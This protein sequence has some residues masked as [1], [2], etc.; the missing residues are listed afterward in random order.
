MNAMLYPF[1]MEHI[2]LLRG[3]VLSVY[4]EI[5]PI[6]L[7]GFQYEGRD[8]GDLDKGNKLNIEVTTNF[9]SKLDVISDIIVTKID[10]YILNNLK[11]AIDLG[12]NIV[13]LQDFSE[14]EEYLKEL[15]RKGGVIFSNI[16]NK[17]IF[18]ISNKNIDLALFDVPIVFVCGMSKNTQKFDVFLDLYKNFTKKGYKISGVAARGE[19]AILPVHNIPQFLIEK[20]YEYDKILYFNNY[21]KWLELTEHPDIIFIE[22]PGGIIPYDI[23]HNNQYGV[24]AYIMSQAISSVD[25]A[26]FSMAYNIYDENF[27]KFMSLYAKYRYGFSINMF[28][29]SNCFHDLEVDGN[30]DVILMDKEKLVSKIKE[31]TSLHKDVKMYNVFYNPEVVVEDI[32][33]ELG[34]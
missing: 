19:V 28:H 23:K 18:K 14:Y 34:E 22:I 10:H 16:C 4:T 20:N 2:P 25:Y 12:K 1:Q 30:E 15:C 33:S 24:L 29:M 8:V 32:I 5:F 9:K 17:E 3:K 13:C 11:I 7:D 31:A 27:Y 21:I 6:A 26:I